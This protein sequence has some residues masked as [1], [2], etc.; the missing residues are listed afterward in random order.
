MLS[1]CRWIQV[2]G[3]WEIVRMT[4]H[5]FSRFGETGIYHIDALKIEH[6]GPWIPFPVYIT[7]SPTKTPKV[8]AKDAEDSH[9]VAKDVGAQIAVE[10]SRPPYHIENFRYVKSR[11]PNDC[12]VVCA[13][14]IFSMD[15]RAAKT[16][17]FH[18]GWSTVSG[19]PDGMMQIMAEHSGFDATYRA[20]LSNG[21]VRL[22]AVDGVFIVDCS[23]HI[24]PAINGK[25]LNV[26][27]CD[28]DTIIDVYEI[29]PTEQDD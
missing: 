10:T 18:H 27:G 23:G 12:F 9:L 14:N 1:D 21:S 4:E 28:G 26:N 13:A 20:D 25:I 22:F 15:Y 2:D 3:R 29:H 24:M 7:D 5:H 6:W 19:G 8:T 17:C 11:K 16:L